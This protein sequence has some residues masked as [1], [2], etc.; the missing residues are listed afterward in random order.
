MTIII[1]TWLVVV[2]LCLFVIRTIA[3]LN[4]GAT[5]IKGIKAVWPTI[6][7]FLESNKNAVIKIS[8]EIEE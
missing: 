2:I 5:V 8:K 7:E 1:P 3:S 4:R 6:K